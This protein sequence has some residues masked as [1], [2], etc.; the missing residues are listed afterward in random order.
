MSVWMPTMRARSALFVFGAILLGAFVVAAASTRWFASF[1]GKLEGD[2]LER[3][4]RSRQ[5]DGKKF[6]NPIPTRMLVP[7][8]TREMIRH[9]FFGKEQ[10]V[11]PRPVPVVP[12]SATDY[13]VP[14]PSGLR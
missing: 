7:G 5:F 2:R 10:R 3:A 13:A 6:V 4:R 8:T 11:P 12:R 9:Q 1:G 14:P